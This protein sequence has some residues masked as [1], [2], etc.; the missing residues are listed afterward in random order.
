MDAAAAHLLDFSKPFDCTL[1]DQIVAIA[2][3]GLNTQRAAANEFLVRL[4]GMS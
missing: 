1:L 2:M 3:D 4:K